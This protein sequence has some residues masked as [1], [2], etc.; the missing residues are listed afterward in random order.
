[1]EGWQ[2]IGWDPVEERIRSWT[3]DGEGGFAEGWWTREGD[4]WLLRETGIT[5]DGSRTGA[6]NTIRRIGSRSIRVGIEQ[7]DARR[8]AP[9]RYRPNRNQPGK[10][11]M[12]HAL[13]DF[14]DHSV[15]DR[16]RCAF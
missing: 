13:T 1:V 16:A 9:T 3:F 11:R 14:F 5:P 8:G 12:S 10:G 6:E 2:I 15:R 4:R 7:S